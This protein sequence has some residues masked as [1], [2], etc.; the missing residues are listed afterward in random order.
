MQILLREYGNE[1]YVWVTAKHNGDYFVVDGEL[2]EE[3]RVVS[4]INDNR[5]N[6]IRCSSCGKV[7]PKSGKKFEKHK[8]AARGITPCLQCRKIRAT[9]LTGNKVKY[10]INDDGTY[11]RKMETKVDL[12]CQQHFWEDYPLD[13][14]EAIAGCKYRR[15]GD[16]HG[17]EITDTFTKCP[18]IFD[19]II[20]IDKI[21][22]NGYEK[23]GYY[24]S[25]STEYVLNVE[26]GISA[27][28]NK[29]GIIDRF[30]IASPEGWNYYV[31]YSK[32]YNEFFDCD[33]GGRYIAWNHSIDND[34]KNKFKE[35]VVSLYK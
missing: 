5:K 22:D 18:G 7:F 10:V 3:Y 28:V 29:L 1:D 9:E 16:A 12:R 31:Y 27:W 23:I 30:S 24:D 13:S 14:D 26:F 20:T 25:N 15:C 21:L 33:C 2:I 19:D 35:I 4:V 6:Y 32:K 34:K 17:M 8:E 11:T